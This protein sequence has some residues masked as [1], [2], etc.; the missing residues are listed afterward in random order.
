MK[1][2]KIDHVGKQRIKVYDNGGETVDRYTVVYLDQE[3]QHSKLFECYGLSVRPFHP[4][5]FAQHGTCIAG[6]HL[7]KRIPLH[8]LPFDCIQAIYNDLDVEIPT[9]TTAQRFFFDHAGYSFHP[10]KETA[11]EGKLRCAVEMAKAEQCAI[12]QGWTAEWS[13]DWDI[14]SHIEEF[15]CYTEE[16]TTCESCVLKDADGNVLAS[17]GCIDDAD[18]NYRRVIEAELA[19][20]AEHN[21]DREIEILDAH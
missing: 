9:L 7:G 18:N 10:N 13:D 8:Y 16:P 3:T 1:Y 6:A 4:Q 19:E 21:L 2:Q 11:L 5:G 15:D 14:G 20:E 17:L 12:N